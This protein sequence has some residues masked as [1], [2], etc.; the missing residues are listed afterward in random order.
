M[1]DDEQ[2]QQRDE[3]LVCIDNSRTRNYLN[4]TFS[5][6]REQG[7]NKRL[8]NNTYKHMNSQIVY[9]SEEDIFNKRLP[10]INASL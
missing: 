4:I 6:E 8:R 10:L 3:K 9:P 7:R 5:V 2:Q 1:G